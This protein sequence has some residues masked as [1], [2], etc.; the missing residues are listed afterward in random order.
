MKKWLIEEQEVGTD[1][2]GHG[3]RGGHESGQN[4]EM[5]VGDETEWKLTDIPHMYS[6][7]TDT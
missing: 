2:E 3:R 7:F 4:L 1:P 5:Q 6:I